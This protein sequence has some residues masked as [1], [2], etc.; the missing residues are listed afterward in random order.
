MTSN[1]SMNNRETDAA[2][3]YHDGTKHSYARIHAEPHYLDWENQPLPFKIYSDLEP[4]SLSR[5][6]SSSDRPALEAI[7]SAG[8]RGGHR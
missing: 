4:I 2:W 5:H 6:L 8:D 7:A 3:A 1:E